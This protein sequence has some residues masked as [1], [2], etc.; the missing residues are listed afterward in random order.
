MNLEQDTYYMKLALEQA[1][2]AAC[3]GE[4]PV[5][6]VVVYDPIDPATRK[7]ILDEPQIIS[8]AANCRESNA[9][10]AGH[11]EFVALCA[12]AKKLGRW[13]LSGCNVY[14]TLE[15]CL[16]CAGLMH[17]SRIDA[18]IY[19]APDPKAGALGSLYSI[20]NDTRLNHNF[21]VRAGVLKDESVQLLREFFSTRRK[22]AKSAKTSVKAE[23][24]PSCIVPDCSE[25]SR[26]APSC[27]ASNGNIHSE[28]N[29]SKEQEN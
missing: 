11:A 25:F 7:H 22:N 12:A 4:V 27:N 6:T 1:R 21:E 19:A 8:S 18:C 14:V 13:R 15:P 2:K 17:Q 29:S 5:G 20:H 24:A 10:P 23:V 26:N 28:P 3:A 9:D 16:M